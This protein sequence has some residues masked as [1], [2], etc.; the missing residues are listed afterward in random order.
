MNKLPT[1]WNDVLACSCLSCLALK[2]IRARCLV[3]DEPLFVYDC[4][5]WPAEKPW[6]VVSI[7]RLFVSKAPDEDKFATIEEA[8]AA[9]Q[10]TQRHC[11]VMAS[12]WP[13]KPGG[14]ADYLWHRE[15]AAG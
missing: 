14:S 4:R 15:E 11:D 6:V 13:L 5:M 3:A 2:E 7:K 1:S 12:S 8:V 9:V 10:K